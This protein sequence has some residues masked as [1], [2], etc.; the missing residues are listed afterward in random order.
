MKAWSFVG[1][2]DLRPTRVPKDVFNGVQ[3]SKIQRG[4]LTR[5]CR[6]TGCKAGL[7]SYTVFSVCA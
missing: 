5:A 1:F 3:G 6:N 2:V 4:W 7:V